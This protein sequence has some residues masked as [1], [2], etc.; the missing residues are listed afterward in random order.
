ML[1]TLIL[2]AVICLCLIACQTKP[3]NLVSK[4]L[5]TK[6]LPLQSFIVN[7]QKDTVLKTQQ[8]IVVKIDA[9]SIEAA[10]PTVTL[11]IK[12]ALSLEDILKAGLV[13]Q[14]SNGILSSEGMFY[15]NTK[16]AS[17][18][19]K[20]LQIELPTDAFDKNMELYK[21]AEEDGK[22]VWQEPTKIDPKP[23][24]PHDGEALF[25]QNCASC[26][27]IDKKLVGPALGWVEDRW[28][29]RGNLF[30]Y[31]R[32]NQKFM[33]PVTDT[34][35]RDRGYARFLYCQ[36]NKTA[37]NIFPELADKDIDGIL[38]YIRVESKKVAREKEF[39]YDSCV[40]LKE[41]EL[42]LLER[43]YHLMKENGKM[44]DLD[45]I[46]LQNIES[47]SPIDTST[48]DTLIPTTKIQK[49]SPVNYDAEYYKFKIVSY[50][51]Y[52]IDALLQDGSMKSALSVTIDKTKTQRIELFLVIPAYKILAEGGLLNDGKSYGF[53]EQDGTVYLPQG[54][55]AYVFAIGE[56][57]DKTYFGLNKFTTSLN[58]TINIKID[59]TSKEKIQRSMKKLRLDG[60]DFSIEKTKNYDSIKAIDRELETI[61]Q[62]KEKG[63]GCL[64]DESR[65]D[66]E[67]VEPANDRD[68]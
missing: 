1:K 3:E 10:T 46:P 19:K 33:Q 45:R 29:S 21:G 47:A 42:N 56:E 39:G 2:S 24:E 20:P 41:H 63:C 25:K 30:A 32:D 68:F 13:T 57:N 5:N 28:K 27:A 14:T 44:A 48:Y 18:I 49:V 52:N 38:R 37:M 66:F 54:I 26:H 6:N 8:G 64:L 51:W 53:Y 7:T 61:K 11:Q 22:I 58:Q 12:E 55:D 17:T 4:Y 31:I 9:G 34:F 15:I 62:K 16:E 43:K 59:E 40:Y 67:E 50:G 65:G 35:D 60:V 23:N 36:Y